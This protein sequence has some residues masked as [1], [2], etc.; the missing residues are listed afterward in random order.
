MFEAVDMIVCCSLCSWPTI[1]RL[2]NIDPPSIEDKLEW[3]DEGNDAANAKSR[4][5]AIYAS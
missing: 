4:A 2:S 5:E 3:L 1:T